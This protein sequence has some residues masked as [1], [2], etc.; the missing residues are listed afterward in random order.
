MNH[1]LQNIASASKRLGYRTDA[2]KHNYRFNDFAGDTACVREAAMAVF[3]QTPASYRSA[4]FGV[5]HAEASQAAEV[6][7]RHRALGAPLFFV[8][9]SGDVSVWQ[10]FGHGPAR[11]LQRTALG[12]LDTLFDTNRDVWAP[13]AI[14]RAKSIGK[15]DSAYQLDFVDAGLLPA[16]EGQIHQKL[17]RLLTQALGAIPRPKS[18]PLDD[19]RV[20]RGIFRLL[21]AKILLDRQHETSKHWNVD[22]VGSVL[23]GIGEYYNLHDDAKFA[24]AAAAK[25]MAAAWAALRDGISVAN[26]SADDLAYVYEN[27]LVT[28]ETRQAFGTHSTPRQVAEF[29]SARLRL[30]DPSS[31]HLTVYEPFTGAGVLLVA[32]LRHLRE[33]LPTDWSDRKRHEHLVKHLRGSEI[34]SFACEVATLSL[35]LADY[36]NTNGWKI[37]NADLFESDKLQQ[38]LK[39]AQVILCNP[40]FEPLTTAEKKRYPNIA[41]VG[42]N[43]AEAVLKLAIQAN[44]SA[45][46]FVLPRAL[47]V[48]RAYRWHRTEIE[49]RYGDIELVSLPDKIFAESQVESA[50]LIAR[51]PRQQGIQRV[52]ASEVEDRDRKQFLAMGVPSQTRELQRPMGKVADG[53]LWLTRLSAVWRRLA[54]LPTLGDS[55]ECHWGLRWLDKGQATAATNR[56]AAGRSEGLMRAKDHRQFLLGQTQWLDIRPDRLYGGGDLS[57][58]QPKILCNA[59]RSGR[60]KWRISAAVDR[61]G[62]VASQQFAV[63]WPT[64]PNIDLDAMAAII[65][66]PL[67]NAYMTEH[68][69]DRRLRIHTLLGLPV[70][71]TLPL[72]VGAMAREYTRRLTS[73]QNPFID[74]RALQELLDQIDAM[75]LEAYDLPPKMVRDLLSE[76][77]DTRRPVAH[78]W[79]EWGVTRADSAFSL[80]ELRSAWLKRSRGNW[81][82][83]ELPP[84]PVAE[85]RILQAA[86]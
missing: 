2:I 67:A 60:G 40:P 20:F 5:A 6:V 25:Q 9:E 57:W 10:V 35:I 86:E 73:T 31:S 15:F 82:T 42:G 68:S 26:I 8:I 58:D 78:H 72:Q 51:E 81:P 41:A 62:L 21:A 23:A 30:W 45:L 44:P 18:A 75:V 66:G 1:A 54:E 38:E 32:A 28:P 50:L 84:V 12:S 71:R 49:R 33:A 7:G 47:L 52:R 36:P 19:R 53:E 65:N 37:G 74:E 61:S 16:I 3:T 22:D 46:G 14:H 69:Q 83:Y 17:D 85:S 39:S 80:S 24:S 29:I 64:R 48:D 27:T 34:D 43:K 79:E 56:P 76:F 11:L 63:L 70:P 59:G 4:A 77:L 13:D 55:F